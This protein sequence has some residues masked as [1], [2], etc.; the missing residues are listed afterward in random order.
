[1]VTV[2]D[3]LVRVPAGTHERDRIRVRSVH[4]GN[5]ASTAAH[6]GERCA[7]GLAGVARDAVRRGDWLVAPAAALATDRIDVELTVWQGEAKA[8]RSG[9]PVSVHLGAA[10]V[11]GSVALLDAEALA[12]GAAARAQLVL[13]Q[14]IG[15]WQGDRFAL[16]DASA[17]RT[18][19]GG[20]VLDP[21]APARYRRTPQRLRQLDALA[22]GD[23][24]A[25]LAQSPAGLDVQRLQ[26]AQARALPVDLGPAASVAL[27]GAAW[28][29]DAAHA[30]AGRQAVLG[31]LAAYHQRS[32]E[33]LGPDAGRLR[34]LALPRWPEP[35]WQALLR[36]L[37]DTAAVVQ[38]GTFVHLPEHGLKLSAVD[39]RIAQKIGP[40]LTQAGFEG[41]WAR[42]LARDVA[43][44]EPLMRVAIARLAQRGE[45][46][47]VVRDLV[48]PTATLQR[49]GRIAR[50]L[51][52]AHGGEVTAAGFRDATQLGRKRAIQIL[53]Y[54]DRIGMLRR[55]GD[56][57]RLRSDSMLFLT[58]DSH[59]R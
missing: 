14:P 40:R 52:A 41:A 37:V 46:H 53:E 43:E 25:L 6:A 2:G 12:P 30:D 48:Y 31:A 24:P 16:R 59:G 35:L 29:I 19:A 4:A 1:V 18:L 45:V 38:R 44:S 36:S 9:T 32:P 8:L 33:E 26:T 5:L 22:A 3:E 55:V 58:N 21:F 10:A 20:R 15:A 28:A 23:A 11:Q 39:E 13:H 47:Q 56:V 7:L 57:H 17:S 50:E 42:D 34:R 49:L 54:L 51:A 27:C